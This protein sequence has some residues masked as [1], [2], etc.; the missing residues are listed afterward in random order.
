MERDLS[1]LIGG[2]T[3]VDYLGARAL[4]AI[5]SQRLRRWLLGLVV[6]GNLLVLAYWK[7]TNFLLDAF[8]STLGGLD[9][10]PPN[11]LDII[12]PVGISFFVFQGLSYVVDVYRGM[13]RPRSPCSNLLCISRSSRNWLPGRSFARKTYFS[14]SNKMWRW[15]DSRRALVCI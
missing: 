1:L 2:V 5:S 10:Y 7:Y 6:A 13:H 12:L 14:N 11:A 3:L 4:V 8:R 9:G 15:T